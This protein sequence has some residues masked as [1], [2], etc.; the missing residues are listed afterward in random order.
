MGD[1][2]ESVHTPPMQL[3]PALHTVDAP[4]HPPQCPGSVMVLVHVPPQFVSPL[5]HT[6]V[7]T[8]DTHVLPVV[9]Q[10][11]PHPPQF[12]GSFL[13]STHDDPHGVEPPSHTTPQTPAT[14]D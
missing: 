13:V 11:V 10:S 6:S 4:L 8:P 1:R 2:H 9:V 3:V 14:H 5:P 12:F 7:Q